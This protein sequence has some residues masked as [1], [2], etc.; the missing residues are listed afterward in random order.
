MNEFRE[1]RVTVPVLINGKFIGAP[2]TA[3]NRVAQE[4]ASA[5]WHCRGG[6]G[7]KVL[8][9]PG[10]DKLPNDPGVPC[11]E[12]GRLSGIPWEQISLP[13]TAR[14]EGGV[15]L[16]F[17]NRTPLVA[18]RALT[19]LHDAQE[20]TTPESNGW[21]RAAWGRLNA[22][23]AGRLQAGLLTVSEFAKSE[24]VRLGIAPAERIHVVPN[25][26]DHVLRE[27]A[28]P[29]VLDRLGVAPRGY[30][31]AL[32]N[33]QV[34]KNI[35]F[36]LRTFARSGLAGLK[37]VLTGRGT[38]ADF[39]ALGAEASGNVIFAG[40]VGDGELRALQE[41]ALAVLTPSLTEG[42][43][44]PPVEAMLL[45]TPAVIAPCGALPEVCGPGALQADPKDP[46]AWEAAILRIR[47]E[48]GLFQ[49]LSA[50]GRD[51]A[52]C[53]TWEAAGRRLDRVIDEVFG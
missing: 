10:M 6:R 51:F 53:F 49:S 38:K 43:G 19:M 13:L 14:R 2:P 5:L 36:L 9:P 28:E 7:V 46:A 21:K 37:L 11:R 41:N 48:A 3:V 42:F 1:P 40:Y 50:A 26:V 34:H 32:A 30:A 31:L 25:G 29:Q 24:L 44:M 33:L 17:Y 12:V 39:A 16:N 27:A 8:V 22:R 52:G 15:L 18:R 23:A 4:L 47:D 45:G 35:P 20:F